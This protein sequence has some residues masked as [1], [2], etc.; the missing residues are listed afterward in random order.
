MAALV[1]LSHVMFT[2]FCILLTPIAMQQLSLQGVVFRQTSLA[3][4]NVSDS[5]EPQL[6]AAL[7]Y[8]TTHIILHSDHFV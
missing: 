4:K 8:L 7:F 1:S 2:F 3:L 6:N 5:Q